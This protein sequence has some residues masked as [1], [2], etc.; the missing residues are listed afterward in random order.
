MAVTGKRT[1]ATRPA[2]G[3]DRCS[4]RWFVSFRTPAAYGEA[5]LARLSVDLTNCFG[6]GFSVDRLETSRLFYLAYTAPSISA[7]ASRKSLAVNSARESRISPGRPAAG[8]NPPVGRT[9]RPPR[10][11]K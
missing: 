4:Q 7:T 2:L 9:V 8:E 1:K 5:L 11:R 6:R 3:Y 10:W